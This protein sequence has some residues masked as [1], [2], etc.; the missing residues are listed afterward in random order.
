M[1]EL[2]LFF[3]WVAFGFLLMSCS[4]GLEVLT[5]GSPVTPEQ[6]GEFVYE[7]P[8]LAWVAYQSAAASI[9][10]VGGLW[11]G[12]TLSRSGGALSL[13]G[14]TMLAIQ[15]FVFGI[16]S[17]DAPMGSLLHYGSMFPALMITAGA[18]I[19]SGRFLFLREGGEG[20]CR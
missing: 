17:Q 16:L 8:A 9:A 19:V 12:V 5:G 14:H 4:F 7:I 3:A 2:F 20:D 11:A 15:F 18:A 6:Y 1:R 10:I 13:I